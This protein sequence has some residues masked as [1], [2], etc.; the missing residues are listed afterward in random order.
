V[1]SSQLSPGRRGVP[2]PTAVVAIAALLAVS[3]V[4]FT[5]GRRLVPPAS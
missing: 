2:L 5:V 4:T 1:A 3:Y